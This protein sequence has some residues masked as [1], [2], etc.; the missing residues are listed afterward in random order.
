MSKKV[1]SPSSPCYQNGHCAHL[2]DI[3][4]DCHKRCNCW[5]KAVVGCSSWGVQKGWCNWP[6]NFDPIWIESCDSFSTNA[7]DR[8]AATKKL[9]P[10]IEIM[11][12]LRGR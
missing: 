6:L 2:R 5:D 8:K 4:G 3:P 1:P 12:M 11:A 10:L 7:K 9:D